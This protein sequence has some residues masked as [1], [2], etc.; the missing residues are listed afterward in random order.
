MELRPI[1]DK[2]VVEKIEANKQ[3]KSGLLIPETAQEKPHSGIVIS[4]GHGFF[5]EETERNEHYVKVG[6]KVIF[7]KYGG[8]E[9]EVEDKK[10]YIISEKDVL[11]VIKE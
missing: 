4:V 11:A 1:F 9:V 10:L 5:S 6:D 7:Q 8:T 3:T 2:I